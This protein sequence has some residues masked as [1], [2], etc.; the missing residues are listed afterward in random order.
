MHSPGIRVRVSGDLACFT[1]PE[2]KV[3]RFTYP[4]ITPS[5]ARNVLDAICWRPQMRWIVTRITVLKPF[6]IS[7]CC[8]TRSRVNSHRR[9]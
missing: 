4:V 6:A 2:T 1:R 9:R 3:E 5:A 8:A 7:A